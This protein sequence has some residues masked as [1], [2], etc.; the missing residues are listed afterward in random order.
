M[1]GAMDVQSGQPPD[2][3]ALGGALA[4]HIARQRHAVAGV[5]IALSAALACSLGE[6]CLRI[7]ALESEDVP[8]RQALAASAGRLCDIRGQL[9]E[10]A[11]ED[12]ATIGEY[13]AR[14]E[15]GDSVQGQEQLCQMP[16]EM[17]KLAAEAGLILQERRPEVGRVQDDLE[18]ALALLKGA[19]RA[20]ILLLDSNLRIW[21][22]A[23]LLARFEPE[24]AALM[25]LSTRL[26]PVSRVRE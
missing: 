3:Q 16:V 7:S 9:L 26:R 21:P 25:A 23:D 22:E 8:D 4:G 6:A 1:M 5:T 24:L 11:E 13:A 2:L 19:V 10:L 14:R 20:A 12:G 17:A 15:A 18:M